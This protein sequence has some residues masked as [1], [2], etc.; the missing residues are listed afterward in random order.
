MKSN[1]FV[2]TPSSRKLLF[3]LLSLFFVALV[4]TNTGATLTINRA[5]VSQESETR[6]ISIKRMIDHPV[7]I[8]QIRNAQSPQ[9]LRDLEIEIQNVSNKPVYFACMHIRFPLIEVEPRK[10]YGFSLH[11][12]D[13]KFEQVDERASLQDQPIPVGGT[14]TLKVPSAISDGFDEYKTEKSLPPAAT[15]KVEIWLMEVSFGDGTG[16]EDGPY[17]RIKT[18]G[19][20]F[21]ATFHRDNTH[22]KLIESRYP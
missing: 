9:F 6:Q 2:L 11:Y 19:K 7:A 3:N 14:V 15:N 18:S 12:G 17:P 20:S 8:K 16:Y 22:R 13:L 5:P 1:P 21:P 10:H 4:I